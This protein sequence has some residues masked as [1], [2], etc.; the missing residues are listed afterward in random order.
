[1]TNR[2]IY[3]LLNRE[4]TSETIEWLLGGFEE[5]IATGVALEKCL[6][7]NRR[8]FLLEQRN[9]HI[10]NA[11]HMLS[12]D[13]SEN[14]RATHLLK[15]IEFFYEVMR[16]HTLSYP[17]STWPAL[18]TEIYYALKISIGVPGSVRQIINIV[19]EQ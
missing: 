15:E 6:S 17:D 2:H 13:L 4:H 18:Q 7:I 10:R 5:H 11:W 16:L 8:G 14:Q 12:T 1:M 9:R 19:N 3:A